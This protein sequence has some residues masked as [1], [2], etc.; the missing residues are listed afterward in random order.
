MTNACQYFL[1]HMPRKEGWWPRWAPFIFMSLATVL[2]LLSPL[3]NLVVSVC[4]AS[5]HENGY[6]PAIGKMLDIAYMPEFGTW[7]MQAYTSLGYVLM[8]W[9]TALQ[10]DLLAR[11]SDALMHLSKSKAQGPP[12]PKAAHP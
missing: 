4:M 10:I 11:I 3:K 12:L 2:L 5:F 1:H 9:A 7:P 8:L 6:D